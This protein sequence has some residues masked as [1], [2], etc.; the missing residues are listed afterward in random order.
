MGTI[1]PWARAAYAFIL[2]HLMY[3]YIFVC[4]EALMTITLQ[5]MHLTQFEQQNQIGTQTHQG[6]HACMV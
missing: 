3:F 5:W 2:M 6:N 1:K 4:I